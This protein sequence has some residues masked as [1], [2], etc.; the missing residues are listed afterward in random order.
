MQ[1]NS[2]KITNLRYNTDKQAGRTY[3]TQH[4]V[5]SHTPASPNII[6]IL[7]KQQH[8][9]KRKST[10]RSSLRRI[11]VG[12]PRSRRRG[13]HKNRG[14]NLLRQ[15][16]L[17]RLHQLMLHKPRVAQPSKHHQDSKGART[18][19]RRRLLVTLTK[20]HK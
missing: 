12:L 3:H 16:E 14:G 7:Y 2:R 8:D 10:S 1:K 19:R 6:Y 4:K 20:Q 17:L 15:G 13:R 11:R 5:Q 18:P 9:R